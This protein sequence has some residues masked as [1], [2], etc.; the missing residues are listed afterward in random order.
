MRQ[1]WATYRWLSTNCIFL[2]TKFQKFTF[3][4]VFLSI[5]LYCIGGHSI[6]SELPGHQL[7]SYILYLYFVFVCI[8]YMCIFNIF[9]FL[10]FICDSILRRIATPPITRL[11]SPQ[12][13]NCPVVICICILYICVYSLSVYIVFMYFIIFL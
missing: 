9:I 11:F 6:Q 1:G 2:K 5:H 4:V 12:L 8:L 13:G 7:P 10:F 3:S